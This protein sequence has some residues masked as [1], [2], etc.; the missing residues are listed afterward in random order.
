MEFSKF[1]G[2]T[3]RN[4]LV[5]LFSI[6]SFR[7]PFHPSKSVSPGM[8]VRVRARQRF[9]RFSP[10]SRR[11]FDRSRSSVTT[12]TCSQATACIFRGDRVRVRSSEKLRSPL[13]LDGS[14]RLRFDRRV[15]R[16]LKR[17]PYA[18]FVRRLSQH[19]GSRRSRI[20][21]TLVGM[22]QVEVSPRRSRG[23]WFT[24]RASSFL[25]FGEVASSRL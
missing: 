17:V 11:L 5:S 3:I 8:Y 10:C 23:C 22:S 6:P 1:F 19:C 15:H 4:L 25:G 20:K 18:S 12:S 16:T 13:D 21:E 14:R 24:Q 7:F 9:Q 2:R